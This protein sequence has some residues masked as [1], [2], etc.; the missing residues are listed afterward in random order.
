MYEVIAKSK[1]RVALKIWILYYPC[2]LFAEA[3]SLLPL[4]SHKLFLKS[5]D[6]STNKQS[7]TFQYTFATKT[8]HW[9]EKKAKGKRHK[10]KQ[11]TK[12]EKASIFEHTQN[13]LSNYEWYSRVP[14]AQLANT[15][16]NQWAPKDLLQVPPCICMVQRLLWRHYKKW[17]KPSWHSSSY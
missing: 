7:S 13:R 1:W 5:D 3:W 17:R 4:S 8:K 10:A 14:S 11:V 6:T 16:T 2:L 15:G 9:G 12:A